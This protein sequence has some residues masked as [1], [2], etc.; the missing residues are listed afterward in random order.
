VAG[1]ST[2][3]VLAHHDGRLHAFARDPEDRAR[4]VTH[5]LDSDVHDAVAGLLSV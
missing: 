2:D 5:P 3:L 1:A 4:L